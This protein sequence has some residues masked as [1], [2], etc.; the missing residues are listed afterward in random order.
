MERILTKTCF[1]LA[2]LL[3]SV[4]SFSQ[5]GQMNSGN[6]AKPADTGTKNQQGQTMQNPADSSGQQMELK[7][8]ND[9]YRPQ[10]QPGESYPVDQNLEINKENLI[11]SLNDLPAGMGSQN[12]QDQVTPGAQGGVTPGIQNQGNPSQSSQPDQGSQSVP[13]NTIPSGQGSQ[14]VPGDTA[15]GKNKQINPGINNNNL[16]VPNDQGTRNPANIKK[17]KVKPE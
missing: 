3:I 7:S 16:G 13:G 6:K 8:H 12:S 9:D 17:D 14:S 5:Q 15:S 11:N 1:L 2:A 10:L 4:M